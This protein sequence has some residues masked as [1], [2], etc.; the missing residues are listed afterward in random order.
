MHVLGLSPGE[1]V[2]SL[3]TIKLAYTHRSQWSYAAKDAYL[4]Q[5]DWYD[6]NLG[7]FECYNF[8][9]NNLGERRKEK[10]KKRKNKKEKRKMQRR[11]EIVNII[12]SKQTSSSCLWQTC[13]IRIKQRAVDVWK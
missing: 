9:G 11:R 1:Q 3:K 5:G 7:G 6:F 10:R 12:G 2:D 8:S 4:A 13:F